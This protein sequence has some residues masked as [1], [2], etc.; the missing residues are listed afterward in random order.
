[1]KYYQKCHQK[2]P[3]Q[4]EILL[5]MQQNIYQKLKKSETQKQKIKNYQ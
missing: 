5:E 3:Y 2:T 4:I 1:M